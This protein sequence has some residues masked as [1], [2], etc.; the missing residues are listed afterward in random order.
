[1]RRVSLSRVFASAI[2]L[3]LAL[4]G[5]AGPGARPSAKLPFHVAVIPVRVSPD[6]SSGPQTDVIEYK[7]DSA[8]L[9]RKLAADLEHDFV[10]VTLL[11][12]PEGTPDPN[13]DAESVSDAAWI[14]MA[15]GI[16]ADLLLECEATHKPWVRGERNDRFWLNLP[17]YLLGGPICYFVKDVTYPCEARLQGSFHELGTISSGQ[18]SLE[19]GLALV[20]RSQTRFEAVSL[21]FA[22]RASSKVG[23]YS[24]TLLLPP[25][26]LSQETEEAAACVEKAVVAGLAQGFCKEVSERSENFLIVDRLWDFY[27]EPSARAT[28][29][30]DHYRLR[31]EVLIDDNGGGRLD[32]YRVRAGDETFVADFE[33][34]STEVAGGTSRHKVRRYPIDTVLNTLDEVDVLNLEVIEGGRTPRVRTFTVPVAEVARELR[35]D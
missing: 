7:I 19:D 13:P 29:E 21:N 8:A 16:H 4:A 6:R 23:R 20:L 11:A 28:P 27:L 34:A 26:L 14:Q 12:P 30:G 10:R 33:D 3:L 35:P 25:G 2:L 18:A 24:P 31:A 22:D 32:A 5:C 17:L 9:S 15:E 1:M